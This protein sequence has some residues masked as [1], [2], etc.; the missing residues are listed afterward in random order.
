MGKFY[1][2]NVVIYAVHRNL[3]G[4]ISC[5]QNVFYITF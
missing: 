2:I 5:S 3:K 1:V 4:N